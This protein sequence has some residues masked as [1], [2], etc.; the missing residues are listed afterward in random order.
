MNFLRGTIMTSNNKKKPYDSGNSTKNSDELLGHAMKMWKEIAGTCTVEQLPD[1]RWNYW[2][3]WRDIKMALLTQMEDDVAVSFKVEINP[4]TL[5]LHDAIIQLSTDSGKEK[6]GKF[7]GEVSYTES[8][9]RLWPSVKRDTGGNYI[10]GDGKGEYARVMVSLTDIK[11][12]IITQYTPGTKDGRWQSVDSRRFC[13]YTHSIL[14][15][16]RTNE[17]KK[18]KQRMD[19]LMEL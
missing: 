18:Q 12:N 3:M 6:F 10:C 16:F 2:L 17:D 15:L 19:H 1:D 8:I 14:N 11:Y 7:C 9:M 4:T 5:R 13:A